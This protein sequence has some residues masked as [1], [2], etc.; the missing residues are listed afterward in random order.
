MPLV[1]FESLPDVARVWVFGSARPLDL[2][3]AADMLRAVDEYLDGWCAHGSPLTVG[4]DWR[5]NCFLTIA[6]DP[7][8]SDASG[9][10]LDALFRV[11]KDLERGMGTSLI[12]RGAIFFRD[13]SGNVQSLD[14]AR[15]AELA[16]NASITAA[17]V[18]FDTSV[19]T[20]GEWRDRFETTAGRAWHAALIPILA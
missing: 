20:L 6:V 19:A 11:F 7:R 18:V 3:S 12:N 9:C 17:S 16:S 8:S 14:R 2:E 13:E 1:S 15:F 5:E 10:S 4:R